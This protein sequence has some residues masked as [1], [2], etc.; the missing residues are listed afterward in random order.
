MLRIDETSGTLVAP[1]AGGLVTENSPER[2][3][4]L[5]LIASSWPAFAQELGRPSLRLVA[6]EP[7]PGVDL[8]AFDEQSGRAVVLHVTGETADIG[9]ALA[10]AA[11]VAG[12]DAAR[13]ASVSDALEAVVPGDSPQLVL[14]AG[15][16]DAAALA[17]V[18]WLARRHGVE[19]SAFSVSV[20]RFGNERLL[21]VHREPR[22]GD[23][24]D[25]AA[26]VQWMLTGAKPAPAAET[27]E[28]QSLSSAPPPGS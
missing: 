2:D 26:A 16:Y 24:R 11:D 17:T 18:E 19:V 27:A 1:Q 9:R 8:L 10:A 4:L 20:L 22:E 3:E 15:G 13:L 28:A 5:S 6:R 23:A 21:S 12:W 25:A 7:A 14:V